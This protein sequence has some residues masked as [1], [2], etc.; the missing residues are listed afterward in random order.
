MQ[1]NRRSLFK[2]LLGLAVATPVIA[3]LIPSKPAAAAIKDP[4][5]DYIYGRFK[6]AVNR[7]KFEINDWKT[8]TEFI[9]YMEGGLLSLKRDKKIRDFRIICDETNNS[10]KVLEENR[11]VASVYIKPNSTL[12]YVHMHADIRPEGTVWN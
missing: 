8:R 11:F 1:L 3:A 4:W 6:W 10:P 9:D 7:S 12:T 2:S 5:I